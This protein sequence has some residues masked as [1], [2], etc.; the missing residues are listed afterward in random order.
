MIESSGKMIL[1]DKILPKFK[2]EGKKVLIFS[3][4]IKVLYYLEMY[5]KYRGYQYEIIMGSIKSKE[6]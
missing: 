3:Q 5:L 1:L 4:F 6:R 2:K